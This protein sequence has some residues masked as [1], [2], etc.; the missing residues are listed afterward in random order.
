VTSVG[1]ERRQGVGTALEAIESR[2]SGELGAA[3]RNLETGEEVRLNAEAVFPT[4]SVIKVPILVE[5]MRRA[6]AGELSL[7]RR[8]SLRHADRIGGS[9]VLK[10][11]EPGVEPTL[12]DVATLMIV[13]SDNTATNMAIDALGGVDPVN[14]TMDKL[15]FATIR[16]HNRI[17]FDLIGSDVRRL[18][19]AAPAEMC[20]LM[21]GIATREVFGPD[22]SQA[23]EDV[24]AQQQYLDQVPRYLQFNPYWRELDDDPRVTVACKT[25]FFTG[26]R[27]D[28][29]IVRFRSGGGF[30]YAVANHLC[31]DE[32]FLPEAE[33][34]VVNGL[35]GKALLEHWWPVA[36]KP[37]IADT[38][39]D[40]R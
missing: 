38:S 17:D 23:V 9:G 39:Y 37:P 4:A 2:C 1:D 12:R 19:E 40:I 32:T 22:V 14:A 8:V 34:A 35:V 31:Q 33:G 3:A 5:M 26:T 18:G 30:A 28:A 16:L 11:F 13:L 20:A 6:Q 15:G 29:G 36:D 7:D 27:V 25:G 24:L 21:H 10:A